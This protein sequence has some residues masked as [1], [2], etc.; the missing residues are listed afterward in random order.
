MILY[1]MGFTLEVKVHGENTN[2]NASDTRATG[3]TCEFIGKETDGAP[4][5]R[6]AYERMIITKATI[7]KVGEN[8]NG[9]AD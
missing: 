8:S 5:I 6:E 2:P 9:V 1:D 4:A 3:G 7:I